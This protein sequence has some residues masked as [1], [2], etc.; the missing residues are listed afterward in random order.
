[1]IRLVLFLLLALVVAT[2]MILVINQTGT[3]TINWSDYY[4]E[5]DIGFA[6]T[7][8]GLIVIAIIGILLLILLLFNLPSI[9]YRFI[10]QAAKTS[11]VY[12]ALSR[13]LIALGSGDNIESKKI[14]LYAE[15]LIKQEPA[16][17][18]LLAQVAQASG[19]QADAKKRF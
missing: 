18:L 14:G 16:V 3:V 11:W 17:Q 12:D 8:I 15:K 5:T 6:L 1:M 7:V 10:F 4:I 19:D 9:I 13:G 2:V